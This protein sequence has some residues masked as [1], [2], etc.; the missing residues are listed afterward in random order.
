MGLS[1]Y[2]GFTGREREK[3]LRVVHRLWDEGKVPRPTECL[4]ACH[5]TEGAIHGHSEDYSP[6]ALHVHIPI[7]ITCHLMLHMRWQQPVLWENYK[8]AIREGWRGVP[9]EQRNALYEIKRL[10]PP[11][12]PDEW[13]MELVNEPTSGTVLDMLS[14][15]KFIHPNASDPRLLGCEHTPPHTGGRCTTRPTTVNPFAMP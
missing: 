10:Y 7:C 14:P 9:L 3:S 8:A 13:P 12:R 4:L 11:T 5:Q 15:I 1:S 6:G 2:N